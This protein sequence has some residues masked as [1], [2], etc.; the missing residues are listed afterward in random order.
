MLEREKA[1][2]RDEAQQSAQAK[3]D[4]AQAQVI[5]TSTSTSLGKVKLRT[6]PMVG[7][8]SNELII[9][10]LTKLTTHAECVRALHE[11]FAWVEANPITQT[12]YVKTGVTAGMP[13]R[14]TRTRPVTLASFCLYHGIGLTKFRSEVARLTVEAESSPDAQRLLDAFTLI[15][16]AIANQMDEGAMVGLYDANYVSKLRGLRELSDVTTRG[17]SSGGLVLNVLTEEALEDVR[18]LSNL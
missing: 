5:A 3:L 13:F 6:N 16:D 8:Q 18:K 7:A 15:A 1:R 4:A 17:K 14:T 11:Y 9:G 12:E 10:K 2:L